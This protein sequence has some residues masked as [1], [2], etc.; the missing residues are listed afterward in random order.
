MGFSG[1]LVAGV[2]FGNDDNAPMRSVG[3][4][5]FPARAWRQFMTAASRDYPVRPLRS[6]EEGEAIA[7]GEIIERVVS[8]FRSLAG[9]AGGRPSREEEAERRNAGRQ[10][11]E[12]LR[13]HPGAAQESRPSQRPEFEVE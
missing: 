5:D 8:W 13:R 7:A 2:W 3:G 12:W 6:A 10:V 4:G 11:E 1:N 9:Q